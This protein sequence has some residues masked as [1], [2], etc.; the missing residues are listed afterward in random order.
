MVSTCTKTDLFPTP[1]SP[2]RAHD[3]LPSAENVCWRPKSQEAMFH[4]Y[5]HLLSDPLYHTQGR[6]QVWAPKALLYQA[7]VAQSQGP[8]SLLDTSRDHHRGDQGP[9]STR[10]C[11][12]RPRAPPPDALTP[13]SEGKL[14]AGQWFRNIIHSW[15]LPS[16][17]PHTGQ[18]L[19]RDVA[20]LATGEYPHWGPGG[21]SREVTTSLSPSR[22]LLLGS[23]LPSYHPAAGSSALPVQGAC[24]N[25]S[26][27]RCKI[28][29]LE[30]ESSNTLR[31]TPTCRMLLPA[32][33]DL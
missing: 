17:W 29:Q 12:Y 30:Q 21:G 13:T 33:P 31:L 1:S 6:S 25:L 22:M 11:T 15:L 20:V 3:H 28:V 16:S 5:F 18:T 7:E 4:G 2:G 23:W 14:A 32:N 19:A 26:S 27:A 24:F 8:A 10:V 9:H